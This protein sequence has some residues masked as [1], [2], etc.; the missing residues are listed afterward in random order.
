MKYCVQT[1]TCIFSR[2]TEKKFALSSQNYKLCR[3][4]CM[5]CP[6]K[7]IEETKNKY[8][9][10]LNFENFKLCIYDTVLRKDIIYFYFE[11]NNPDSI[12]LDQIYKDKKFPVF[13]DGKNHKPKCNENVPY[14]QECS[15][16]PMA[17]DYSAQIEINGQPLIVTLD[18]GSATLVVPTDPY[19]KPKDTYGNPLPTYKPAKDKCFKTT[20]Y[21]TYIQYGTGSVGGSNVISKL[22]VGSKKLDSM[23][24]GAGYFDPTIL[25]PIY[26]GGIMG[27]SFID[28]NKYRI[29]F[30]KTSYPPTEKMLTQEFW[31]EEDTK[32]KTSYPTF[33]DYYG[34]RYS[35]YSQKCALW[36][37]RNIVSNTTNEEDANKDRSNFGKF[38]LGG[39][40]SLTNL[41]N[42]DLSVIPVIK[43]VIYSKPFIGPSPPPLIELLFYTLKLNEFKINNTTI[44]VSE[45]IPTFID[46]GTTNLSFSNDL[47]DSIKNIF[48]N[49]KIPINCDG[50]GSFWD[51]YTFEDITLIKENDIDIEDVC[52]KYWPVFE[53]PLI[54]IAGNKTIF[55][56]SPKNYWNIK[57]NQYSFIIGFQFT[58]MESYGYIILGHPFLCENYC[59]FDYGQKQ[60][61]IAPRK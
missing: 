30:G 49:T 7:F 9:F 13:A 33:M 32:P 56:I 24:F 50:T 42:G 46:S 3:N 8:P 16:L 45:K 18:T 39:G 54:D 36:V 27:L 11:T 6:K 59:V 23:Q 5:I 17:E 61:K 2:F 4:C 44:S 34:K 55:K 15:L 10:C 22:E 40:E 28:N 47:F 25:S 35:K 57:N 38:I 19:V 53:F 31:N 48:I 26:T 51:K 60:V 52:L 14:V 20:E 43:T 29:Y 37:Q 41:Y 58:S 1:E 21:L 12:L